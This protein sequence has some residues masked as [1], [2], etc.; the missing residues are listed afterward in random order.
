[1]FITVTMVVPTV[2]YISA[3][4]WLAIK[5]KNYYDAMMFGGY[6]FANIGVMW[7]LLS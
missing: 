5:D 7:R 6:S 1:M 4:L 3:A 2:C